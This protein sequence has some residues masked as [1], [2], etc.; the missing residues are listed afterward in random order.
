MHLKFKAEIIRNVTLE[1]A[2]KES[3]ELNL[4]P[5]KDKHFKSFSVSS[6]LIFSIELLSKTRVSNLI[7]CPIFYI[8]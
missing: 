8:F 1:N 2:G 4:F 6:P 3:M 7:R 5:L